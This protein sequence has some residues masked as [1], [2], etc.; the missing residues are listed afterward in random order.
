MTVTTAIELKQAHDQIDRA[1]EILHNVVEIHMHDSRADARV[2]TVQE[3]IR[4]Q[5]EVLRKMLDPS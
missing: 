2:V 4:H 1:E 5:I 3:C